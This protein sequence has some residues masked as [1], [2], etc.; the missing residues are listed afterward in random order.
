MLKM[1]L[2]ILLIFCGCVIGLH[3]SQRLMRRKEILMGFD[4]MFH[5]ASIKIGYNAGDLCEVFSDNFADHVFSPDVPF[6]TQWERFVK[7]YAYILTK[8]DVAMMLE[9]TKELGTADCDA[10]LRHITMYS[11]LIR[12]QIG[13]AQEDIRTKTKMMRIIPAAVGII[14]A[15]LLL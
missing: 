14:I 4:V 11:R 13:D 1:F 15:L 6:V 10:Q 2:C 7:S 12:E 3:L 5:R 8:E 9:F